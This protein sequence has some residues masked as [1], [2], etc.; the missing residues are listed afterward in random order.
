MTRTD[1]LD[2]LEIEFQ[3]IRDL[4]VKRNKSYGAEDD[5]LYNFRQ[6]AIRFFGD[7]SPE[8]MFKVAEILVDKHN[9]ALANKGAGDPVCDERL[10]DRIVYSLLEKVI[11]RV[12]SDKNTGAEKPGGVKM[13]KY[14]DTKIIEAEPGQDPSTDGMS[15]GLAIEA[16]KN[17]CKVAREGWNGKGMWLT[18]VRGSNPEET[19][20][21]Y[22]VNQV[23]WPGECLPW[24]GMKTADD[25]FV[26]W[27]ASQTDILSDDWVIV[28]QER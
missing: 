15:F 18:V 28:E 22:Q 4:F 25:K 24:I 16:L 19:I 27:L 21:D 2:N 3:R 5:L 11:L 13:D 1:F 7:D 10:S 26:P 12:K 8:N 14:I 9:I 17:G 23:V 6:S 20:G